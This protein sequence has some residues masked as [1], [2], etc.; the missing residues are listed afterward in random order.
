MTCFRCAA[1]IVSHERHVLQVQGFHELADHVDD[2]LR[3]EIR[4]AWERLRLRAQ[5]PVGRD[6]AEAAGSA[7]MTPFHRW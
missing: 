1:G 4:I 3:R 2:T 5:G 6:A 7:S